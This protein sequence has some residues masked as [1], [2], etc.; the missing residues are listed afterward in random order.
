MKKETNNGKWRYNLRG[1]MFYSTF[2][3]IMHYRLDEPY[4]I[5]HMMEKRWFNLS[6]FM[7][8]FQQARE[9]AG[10]NPYKP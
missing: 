10:L 2:Y 6:E 1:D 3:D 7:P 9:N 4:L 8:V 5:G